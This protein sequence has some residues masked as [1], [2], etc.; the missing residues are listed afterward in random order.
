MNETAVEA[1]F[2]IES[3]AFF[4]KQHMVKLVAD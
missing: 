3:Y 1:V 4:A 2:F